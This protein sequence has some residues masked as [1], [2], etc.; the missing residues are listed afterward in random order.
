MKKE[1]ASYDKPSMQQLK[2]VYVD[3]G[4]GDGEERVVVGEGG[5]VDKMG[6]EIPA[7]GGKEHLPSFTKH[8]F[9]QMIDFESESEDADVKD[10]DFEISR[11]SSR[12][13]LTNSDLPSPST[14]IASPARI[15]FHKHFRNAAVTPNS[16]DDDNSVF[17]SSSSLSSQQTNYLRKA[18]KENSQNP[19][20]MLQA[21]NDMLPSVSSSS[22]QPSSTQT[23]ST[24]TLTTQSSISQASPKPSQLRK[25]QFPRHSRESFNNYKNN[26]PTADQTNKSSTTVCSNIPPPI[27][28]TTS[29]PHQRPNIFSD[30]IFS[31]PLKSQLLN[32]SFTRKKQ[33]RSEGDNTNNHANF[34]IPIFH[35]PPSP[36]QQIETPTFQSDSIRSRLSLHHWP[37]PLAPKSRPLSTHLTEFNNSCLPSSTE[38]YEQTG[39][40]TKVNNNSGNI[41]SNNN[42]NHHINNS[43]NNNNHKNKINFNYNSVPTTPSNSLT[44]ITVLHLKTLSPFHLST[45]NNTHDEA[46]SSHITTSS[47]L[48]TSSSLNTS[49]A[50][51]K[52]S[53]SSPSHKKLDL[54]GFSI[55]ENVEATYTNSNH[56]D[57]QPPTLLKPLLFTSLKSPSHT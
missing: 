28:S 6:V 52:S 20:E 34:H 30:L 13:S 19:L 47:S 43:N 49:S 46:S 8:R 42:N 16:L 18:K 57:K 37:T 10:V 25:I 24:Q 23:L 55:P 45:S 36:L 38:N 27:P 54:S 3:C 22:N 33:L 53:S 7:D 51:I 2:A 14:S 4:G 11:L 32:Q 26:P 17:S 29:T 31:P 39:D 44:P 56:H 12:T 21:L 35:I 5:L 50:F 15:T 9:S 41:N 1:M 40:H 48:V